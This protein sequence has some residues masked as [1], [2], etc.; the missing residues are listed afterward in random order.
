MRLY[1]ELPEQDTA[2]SYVDRIA[3]KCE[4]ARRNQRVWVFGIDSDAEARS[5]DARPATIKHNPD[6][7]S[8]TPIH[9]NDADR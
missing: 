7:Q 5:N 1:Q 3:G 6:A 2:E 8:R 4:D 9:C